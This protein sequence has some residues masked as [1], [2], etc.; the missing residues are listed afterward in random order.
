MVGH[1]RKPGKRFA[2]VGE[3]FDPVRIAGDYH[4]V[5]GGGAPTGVGLADEEPVLLS[6][7]READGILRQGV[8]QAGLSVFDMACQRRHMAA[9]I[10]EER[11]RPASLPQGARERM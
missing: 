2:Q 1:G 6:E 8:V 11:E 4:R 10:A 7:G 5:E 9:G 3:S